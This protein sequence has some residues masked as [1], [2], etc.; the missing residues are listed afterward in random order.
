MHRVE[1]GLKPACVANCPVNALLFGDLDDP[2]SDVSAVIANKPVFRL[3][4]EL[5]TEPRVYYVGTP[6][7]SR[8]K[9][10]SLTIGPEV[11]A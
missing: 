6:P 5:G 8:E 1:K 11:R 3:L 9:S 4:E 10:R 2:R 7:P